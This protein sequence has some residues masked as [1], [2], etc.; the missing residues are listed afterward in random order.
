[1]F[2]GFEQAGNRVEEKGLLA[3]FG[4][5]R[6]DDAAGAVAAGLRHRAVGIDDVDPGVGA[7]GL[8]IVD[9]HDLV[10]GG[11]RIGV[12][13]DRCLRR[14]AVAAAAHVDDQDLVSKPVHSGK[15]H[16]VG[17]VAIVQTGLAKRR[18]PSFG[19][20]MAEKPGKYQC[21]LRSAGF[22]GP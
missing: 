10:E 13:R 16:V 11:G 4:G 1:M 20:Y 6:L 15:L 18:H 8:R 5:E 12:E 2:L 3:G 7:G 14:H 9:R 17:H 21:R 22:I 19:L